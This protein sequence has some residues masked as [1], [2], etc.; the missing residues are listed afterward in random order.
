MDKKETKKRA[1]KEKNIAIV[2]QITRIIYT[3]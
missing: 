2:R 1:E 3:L